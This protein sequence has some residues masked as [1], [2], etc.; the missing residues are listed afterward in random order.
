MKHPGRIKLKY[1][2]CGGQN[3][4]FNALM[5]EMIEQRNY[6]ETFLKILMYHVSCVPGK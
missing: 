2:D 3:T 6:N 5:I 4:S 1:F